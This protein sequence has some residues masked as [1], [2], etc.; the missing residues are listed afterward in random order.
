MFQDKDLKQY[1]DD[2]GNLI[3]VHN[4]K[5]R[6]ASIQSSWRPHLVEG[7]HIVTHSLAGFGLVLTQ[8]VLTPPGS[9]PDG[10]L[11]AALSLPAASRF[12]VLSWEESSPPGPETP[13]PADQ[14]ARRAQTGRLWW[15]WTPRQSQEPLFAVISFTRGGLT[16]TLQRVFQAW[17]EQSPSQPKHTPT[18]W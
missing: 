4:V 18:R 10:L 15:V 6:P 1:L 16:T 9:D 12:V 2:C 7:I 5:V 13:E 8:L 17:P 14:R 3:N 11:S